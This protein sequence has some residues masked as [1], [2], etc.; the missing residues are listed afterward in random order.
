MPSLYEAITTT[1]DVSSSNFTTLYNASGL[2]VPNAG[3][4][5][6]TGNLNV[7][8]N[9]T[10][11]GTSNLIGAVTIGS[12]LSTPHYTFPLPD[13]TTDQVLVTDGNGN[14]YWSSVQA[15][16]GVN[17]QIEAGTTTGGANLT[18]FSSLTTD[19]VKFANGRNITVTR[20][21]ANTITIATNADDIP[22]GTADG[23][24]LV[25]ESG[26]WTA[27]NVVSADPGP[28]S[29]RTTFSGKVSGTSPANGAYYAAQFM[30][31]YGAQNYTDGSGVSLL[32]AIDS[33]SQV[34]DYLSSLTTAY[35]TGVDGSSF[36]L[37]TSTD[38]F[39]THVATSITGGNTLVFS[40]AHGFT[41]NTPI[42]FRS[43][44]S[45]G[46][47]MDQIYYVLS[48]GL[49]T[50]QCEVSL[51]QGGSA[52]ALT[53][54]TG[55]S[56]FFNNANNNLRLL[57]VDNNNAKVN[58]S[59]LTLRANNTGAPAANA[60]FT[61]E[62]GS[63]G[64]D[65]IIG[66]DETN[67]RWLLNFNTCADGTLSTNSEHIYINAD[68]TAADSFLH[69]KGTAGTPYLKWNNTASQFEFSTT[70]VA[71]G[72][73]GTTYVSTPQLTIYNTGLA[74]NI[75]GASVTT[76]STSQFALLTEDGS[77]LKVLLSIKDNVT[78]AVHGVELFAIQNA[79][80]VMLT[81]YAELYT[82]S[83][84]ATFAVDKSGGLMRLLVTP[85]S[86]NNTTFKFVKTDIE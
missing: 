21:D 20:T 46:L 70:V 55:L 68:N 10:V 16:P 31:D 1:G 73:S 29:T 75:L 74:S 54:G 51:T 22:D 15:I 3:V 47:V 67:T 76:T 62:R 34:R 12:T 5:A 18:L 39:T 4:G 37:S 52:V 85:L 50:T 38:A 25:W 84:L 44:T 79:S 58:G 72:V 19:S 7:S 66:W 36:R 26:A 81:T 61:V 9:L 24:L 6:I 71:P 8:G 82:S 23:Q 59:N 32:F 49:T 57:V 28:A 41:A 63:S 40:S 69:F 53:N 64:A 35:S 13:G 45:N 11:Q 83:A 60:Q 77:V 43:S 30:N 27:T 65:A 33:D 48:T 14:L 78:G 56:L 42:R 80:T 17:Y 2:T 86:T